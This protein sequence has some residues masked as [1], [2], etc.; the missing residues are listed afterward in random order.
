MNKLAIGILAG[1]AAAATS[2]AGQEIVSSGK[3]YKGP[4]EVET[5]CFSAGELQLDIFASWSDPRYQ[6]HED[7]VGGGLGVNY[8][9]HKMIGIGVDGNL[10]DGGANGIWNISGSLIVR[11][12]IDECCIAP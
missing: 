8:F 3:A 5:E 6:G 1:C 12:P 10:Y 7:G 4:V 2:F 11:F 9:F